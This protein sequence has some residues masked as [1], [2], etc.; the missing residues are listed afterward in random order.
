MEKI[1]LTIKNALLERRLSE[2]ALAR[3]VGEDQN[4][5]NRLLSG[6]TKRLDTEL[7][8]KL[9]GALGIAEESPAYG[10]PGK[11]TT[12]PLLTAV[13]DEISKLDRVELAELLSQLLRKARERDD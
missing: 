5:V 7:V 8:G 13:E 1:I 2:S 4:K 6:K 10:V 3:L 9:C 11:T 12:D